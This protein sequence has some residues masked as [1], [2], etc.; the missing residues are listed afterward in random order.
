VGNGFLFRDY[1]VRGLWYALEKSVTFHRLP[2]HVRERQLRR[3]MREARE[4]YSLGSMIAE[5]IRI[6][7]KLNAGRPLI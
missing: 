4:R 6:Y 5:Y 1:D 2:A 3:I 7:E